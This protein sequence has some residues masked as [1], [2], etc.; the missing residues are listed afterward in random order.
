MSELAPVCCPLCSSSLCTRI[1][2]ARS[3]DFVLCAHCS[4]IFVPSQ[5]HLSADEE[6]GI[7]D[8]HENN[9]DDAGYRNFLA[10]LV[11]PMMERVPDG[12]KGLDFGCGPGPTL[13]L[14]FEESAYTMSNYDLFYAPD[15][16]LL[17]GKYDFV[18]A[19]EVV[20]HFR[21]PSEGF[22]QLFACLKPKGVLGLMT[23]LVPSIENISNWHYTRDTTHIAF[24]QPE[25][26]AYI[27]E[28]FAAK[29]EILRQDV[30]ILTRM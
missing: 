18:C 4:L 19:T 21:N 6:K 24:Y 22:E 15:K 13:G 27:A 23:K 17:E 3:R 10:R 8:Y 16:E 28:R 25:A 9:P 1:D 5:F 26:F 30:I 2:H 20:E 14:M 29:V 7:Y 12:A 11:T